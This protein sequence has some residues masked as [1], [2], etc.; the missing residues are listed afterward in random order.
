MDDII[1]ALIGGLFIGISSS[2]MLWGLGRITGISG[3]FSSATSSIQKDNLWRHSFIIGLLLGGAFMFI[4]F[5]DHFFSYEISGS[6]LRIIIAG[7]LVGLGTQLGSGCTSGHGV[8]GISRL[9]KRSLI[10]TMTFIATGIIV[11]G[12]E[13]LL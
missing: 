3:I 13:R 12:L 11:V 6:P 5:P 10:A 1:L 7:L 8:C 4:L 9:S 2:M